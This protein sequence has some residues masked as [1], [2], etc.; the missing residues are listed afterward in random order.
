[1][2]INGE[3]VGWGLGDHST[4]DETVRRA[5]SFM[6]RMY[7]SYCSDL[8]DTNVF[9]Q[10]MF[11]KVK[12]MQRRLLLEGKLKVN[13][14]IVGVLDLPTQ[15]AME[16]KKPPPKVL[17]IIFTVEGHMS[18]MFV[19]PCASVASTLE[20]QGVCHWKPIGY[21]STKLPFDNNSGVQAL[22]DEVKR[23]EIEGP[24]INPANPDGPKVMWPFPIGTPWGIIIF[25]QGAMIGCDFM[26]KYILRGELSWRLESFKR[27]LA[28]GNPRRGLDAICSWASNPPNEG[29]QGIM[30]RLFSTK[31]TV[32]EG[33]WAE[34]ATHGDMF[35]ENTTDAAGKDKTAIAKIVTE[36]SWFGGQSA[37]FAR[38]MTLFQNVP[39]EGIG[40]LKAIISAIMFAASNPNPHYS[41]AATAGDIDW[42]KGVAA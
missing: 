8:A 24:P 3:W 13:G 41:T 2:R 20:R 37:I 23:T 7:R 16:F 34:N 19:G 12:E 39:A 29:T 42:M 25:S 40:A 18:N 38:V 33:K 10:Q 32:L 1:M 36:N 11:D 5:K 17:P 21:N 26:T 4:V 27:G 35:A 28:F 22:F 30:D 31:G 14:Y 15:I 6:R 9:D